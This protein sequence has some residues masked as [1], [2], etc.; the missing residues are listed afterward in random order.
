MVSIPPAGHSENKIIILQE[1]ECLIKSYKGEKSYFTFWLATDIN[2]LLLCLILAVFVVQD[3][4]ILKSL[5][6]VASHKVLDIKQANPCAYPTGTT[7]Q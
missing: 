5:S 2:L 7:P 4:L 3:S 1:R 6:S